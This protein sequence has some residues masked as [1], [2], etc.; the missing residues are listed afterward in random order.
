MVKRST[1][2]LGALTLVG[3]A[4]CAG[5]TPPPELTAAR[6]NYARAA[7][8]PSSGLA[9]TSVY[10]AKQALGQ[11]EHSYAV[12]GD[13]QVTRDLAY[14]ADRRALLAIAQ[15]G[16]LTAQAQQAEAQRKG[17]ELVAEGQRLTQQEL[18]QSQDA[19]IRQRQQLAVQQEQMSARQ[20]ELAAERAAREAAERRAQE[21]MDSLKR[22]GS[23]R[24]EA[25]GTVLTLSGEVL[26]AFN[27]T[28]LRPIAQERLGQVADVLKQTDQKIVIEGH[29]DSVGGDAYNLRLS[30][31]RAQAVKDFLAS[32]GVPADRI[33]VVGYGKARPIADNG[34]PEGRA[35]NRRVEIILRP[36][37][38]LPQGAQPPTQ[39]PQQPSQQPGQQPSRGGQVEEENPYK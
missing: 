4:G 35:N 14:I 24:Q 22:L 19:L 8:G 9:A 27:K 3:A 32:R 15:G 12:N 39:P 29:T 6:Q 28:E 10:E 38:G 7:A 5:T 16:T 30:K 25:R 31:G 37:G 1:M 20:R 18:A 33:E 21:A 11:A 23:V 2:W 26:F 36:M 34:T 17:Q 13:A